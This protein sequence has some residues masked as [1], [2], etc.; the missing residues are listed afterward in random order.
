MVGTEGGSLEGAAAIAQ[1]RV[2]SGRLGGRRVLVA[3]TK[4]T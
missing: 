2:V 3:L 4:A 1:G